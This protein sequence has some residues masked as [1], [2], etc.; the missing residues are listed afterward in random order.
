MR[1]P[2]DILE[3]MWLPLSK[4]EAGVL[5]F[6]AKV[7]KDAK[8]TGYREGWNDALIVVEHNKTTKNDPH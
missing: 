2:E 8:Q 6:I 7:Q 5:D 1:T 4:T 3:N